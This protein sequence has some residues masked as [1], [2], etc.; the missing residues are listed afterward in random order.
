MIILRKKA[1]ASGGG[2]WGSITGTLADQTDLQSALNAKLNL[3]GG[4]M[5]GALTL[6]DGSASIPSL[7]TSSSGTNNIGI[8]GSAQSLL[9][10]AYGNTQMAF[11]T[12]Y[13]GSVLAMHT[14]FTLEWTS[15]G[16]PTI[17]PDLIVGRGGAAATLQLG[18]NHATTPTNQCLKAHNVTT[19]TGGSLE[20]AGGTGSVARGAV[21]LNGGNRSIYIASPSATEIRDILI[22][23]GLM[24][25]S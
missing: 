13:N 10:T 18:R 23:H 16:S 9:F 6:P 25:A 19:G 3:S 1:S 17:A 4:T 20:I 21:T 11:A 8:F 5:T 24:A 12:G 2:A 15:S 22:S 7:K 14:N